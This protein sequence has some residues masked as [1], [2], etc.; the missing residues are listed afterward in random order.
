MK[1]IKFRLIVAKRN[2]ELSI[3][4]SLLDQRLTFTRSP[5]ALP[6]STFRNGIS[7]RL[8]ET[9]GFFLSKKEEEEVNSYFTS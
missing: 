8:I 2:S 4:S 7:W 5:S 3:A 6:L 1:K 9:K